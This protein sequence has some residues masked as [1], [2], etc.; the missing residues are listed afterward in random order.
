MRR[1]IKE[2]TPAVLRV[3]DQLAAAVD[4]HLAGDTATAAAQFRL[5]D[6][7]AVFFWLNPC[8][9]DV[10]ANV[11]CRNP[12]GDTK[13]LPRADRDPQR[14]V[15][16]SVQHEVLI[17]DGYRCRYC[18]LR[19]VSADIRKIAHR[20]YPDAVPWNARDL[21]RQHAG[22]A[23]AWLQYDHV[24]PHSHGGRSDADNVVVACAL[25]NFAKDR[26]TLKQLDLEDP[27]RFEPAA[28]D[29]DGLE[30][31]RARPA[32]E[33]RT[34]PVR[35]DGNGLDRLQ[36]TPDSEPVACRQSL[37]SRGGAYFVEGASLSK[38][39]LY[40]RAINGKSRW[41]R[42]SDEV[43]AWPTRQGAATGYALRCNPVLLHR[44]GIKL[45]LLLSEGPAAGSRLE[46]EPNV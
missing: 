40:T 13:V 6:G 46:G 24:V 33:S 22:F 11:V 14:S 28:T 10:E 38:G 35:T 30:R 7:L 29:W 2:P 23:A 37:Q 27:R 9:Y 4:A 16:R 17:R 3:A 31:L 19:V 5:A 32:A 45:P 42:L 26:F 39:Y 21:R 18:G 12:E 1:C 25:C 41:F 44:R 36:A 43:E 20:I 8:W 34:E 15:P